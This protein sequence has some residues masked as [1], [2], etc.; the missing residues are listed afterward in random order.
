M[1]V[2]AEPPKVEGHRCVRLVENQ[3]EVDG[4]ASLGGRDGRRRIDTTRYPLR[5]RDDP[6]SGHGHP[7]F[8]DAAVLFDG[9]KVGN[10]GEMPRS[11]DVS[12]ST[13]EN[14]A[15]M[16]VTGRSIFEGCPPILCGGRIGNEHI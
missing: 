14:H 15:A 8:C 11:A 13:R 12:L 7:M 6:V 10:I 3:K 4:W 16:R 1:S 2:S 9:C 5:C